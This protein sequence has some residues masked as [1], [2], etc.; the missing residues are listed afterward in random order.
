MA[1]NSKIWGVKKIQQ[2][3]DISKILKNRHFLAQQTAN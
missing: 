1:E 2:L 3:F